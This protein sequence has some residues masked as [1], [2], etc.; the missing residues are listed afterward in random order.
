MNYF[1]NTLEQFNDNICAVTSDGRS[2]LYKEVIEKA[3]SL[4]T[5]LSSKS[6][7][8]IFCRNDYETLVGYVGVL[9]SQSI[10]L[11]INDTLDPEVTATLLATY[12]P[13]YV[14]SRKNE[15]VAIASIGEYSLKK[16]D[17]DLGDM[18]HPDLKL[19]LS[20]S[21]SLGSPKLVKLSSQNIQSNAKSIAS[22][23][24]LSPTELPITTLNMSY[25]YGLSVINSHLLSGAGILLT[26]ASLMTPNFWNLIKEKKVTSFAGVPFIYEM[27]DRLRFEQMDLPSLKTMT[28][29]GGKLPLFLAKK[30]AHITHK[31]NINFY[32]M[33]GQT[34]ATAR[35]S[36]LSPDQVM[37]KYTSIGKAIPGGTLEIVDDKGDVIEMPN[38]IGE[39]VYHGK[40]VMMGYAKTRCELSK[41][42]E[43]NR[44]LRTGDLSSFDE[45]GFFY[46]Q[47]RKSR[48]IKLFGN[49]VNLD[50][51]DH[52]LSEEGFEC[53]TGGEDEQLSVA[54]V[55]NDRVSHQQIKRLITK[56]FRYHHSAISLIAIPEIPR[57]SSGKILYEKVFSKN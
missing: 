18:L 32:I 38:K 5:V 29:A 55:G 1:W 6:L 34:E 25:S 13:D 48:F 40:N 43:M 12:S 28:Q 4:K 22:Y 2:F 39:L 3:D 27:L 49:R 57:N 23:L 24:N 41:G 30:F 26:D 14:W 20:T 19:L 51:I 56:R 8:A 52:F 15:E 9:R 44:T 50:E 45:E 46:I 47:G 42:D 35:I 21:G 36:Y 11:L 16:R 31:K 7:V 53:V 33:Y 37:K 17:V 10:A 54:V